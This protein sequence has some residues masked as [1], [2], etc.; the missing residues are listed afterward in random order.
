MNSR[1]VNVCGVWCCARAAEWMP[2]LWRDSLATG[3]NGSAPARTAAGAR[4]STLIGNGLRPGAVLFSALILSSL[5]VSA[6]LDV[7]EVNVSFIT[8]Q[9]GT[10]AFGV[11]SDPT[12]AQNSVMSGTADPYTY[13]GI[14]HALFGHLGASSFF[15]DE[16]VPTPSHGLLSI[17]RFVDRLYLTV[18]GSSATTYS[19]TPTVRLTGFGA[20]KANCAVHSAVVW[21]VTLKWSMRRRS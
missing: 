10:P 6:P 15:S 9:T 8:N 7:A 12:V 3:S 14:A 19:W 21:A 5:G 11:V 13:S 18:P 1:I 20:W 2:T 4:A 16:R 17:A